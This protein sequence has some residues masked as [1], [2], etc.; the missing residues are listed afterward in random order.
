M[1][2][3]WSLEISRSY[4]LVKGHRCRSKLHIPVKLGGG[5][6]CEAFESFDNFIYK[7]ANFNADCVDFFKKEL[8][9]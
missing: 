9:D 8:L 1:T 6:K 4:K 2:S 5:P 7:T 3:T